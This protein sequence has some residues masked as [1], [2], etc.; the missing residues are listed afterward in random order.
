[1]SAI[2]GNPDVRLTTASR[3]SRSSLATAQR[4]ALASLPLMSPRLMGEAS[5][6]TGRA[7]SPFQHVPRKALTAGAFQAGP[8]AQVYGA[9]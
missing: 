2:A 7:L 6:Y 5:Y 8:A 3:L 1:M 9:P 4:G